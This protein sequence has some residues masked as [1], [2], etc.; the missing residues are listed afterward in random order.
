MLKQQPIKYYLILFFLVGMIVSCSQRPKDVLSPDQM[1]NVLIDMHVADGIFETPAYRHTPT[2]EKSQYYAAILNKYGVTEAQFDSSVVWYTRNPD[3]FDKIYAQVVNQLEQKDKNVKDGMYLSEEE[4][5][6]RIVIGTKDLWT[7]QRIQYKYPDSIGSELYF[8]VRDSSLMANDMYKLSFVY[9]HGESGCKGN[10]L[11]FSVH[12][13]DGWV[14]RMVHELTPDGCFRRVT[15][16][17]QAQHNAEIEYLLG[18]IAERDTCKMTL[19]LD[20][21]SLLR[22]YNPSVQDSIRREQQGWRYWKKLHYKM[23]TAPLINFRLYPDLT[24]VY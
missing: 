5:K 19:Q 18:V 3:Q 11:D 23:Y 4:R 13:N 7:T 24:P 9:Q 6:A 1:R 14:E 12:Y 8:V 16:Y 22:T 15:L 20:S 21:I 10:R 17:A 2:N